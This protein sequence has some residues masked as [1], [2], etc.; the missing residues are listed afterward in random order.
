MPCTC[1][2]QA[3]AGQKQRLQNL[4]VIKKPEFDDSRKY[5]QPLILFTTSWL[6]FAAAKAV[7]KPFFSLNSYSLFVRKRSDL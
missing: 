4:G 2:R 1:L 3:G 5:D 6:K 7:R